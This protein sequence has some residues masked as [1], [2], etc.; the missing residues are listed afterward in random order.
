[1]MST[2]HTTSTENVFYAPCERADCPRTASVH[3]RRRSGLDGFST[4]TIWRG[5]GLGHRCVVPQD[6]LDAN[7]SMLRTRAADDAASRGR[8]STWNF[9]ETPSER[10]ILPADAPLFT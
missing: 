2:Q 4:M 6:L 9:T 8:Q 3:Q 5:P 1:M 10:V 7:E